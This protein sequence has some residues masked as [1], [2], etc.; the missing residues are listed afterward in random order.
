MRY[1]Y[2]NLLAFLLLHFFHRL[3]IVSLCQINCVLTY[4]RAILYGTVFTTL[5]FRTQKSDKTLSLI[6][7]VETLH[8]SK[9]GPT[10]TLHLKSSRLCVGATLIMTL[11]RRITY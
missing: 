9:A 8:D 1:V 4:V 2:L 6:F 10:L 3:K 5:Y 7:W 11:P